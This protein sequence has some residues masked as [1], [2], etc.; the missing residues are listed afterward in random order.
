L[1]LREAAALHRRMH[2]RQ[3]LESK[4]LRLWSRSNIVEVEKAVPRQETES[5]RQ[6]RAAEAAATGSTLCQLYP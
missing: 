5:K 1:S 2:V 6:R 4:R 3:Y